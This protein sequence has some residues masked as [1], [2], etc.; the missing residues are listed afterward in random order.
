MI[1]KHKS[2][3]RFRYS[4]LKKIFE[5]DEKKLQEFLKEFGEK[6]S[7]SYKGASVV[8]KKQFR[9]QIQKNSNIDLSDYFYMMDNLTKE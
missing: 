1:K 3:I 8:D 6:N 5:Y 9:K 2:M 7:K 4:I